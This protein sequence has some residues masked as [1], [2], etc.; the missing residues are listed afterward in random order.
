MLLAVEMER[1]DE[2]GNTRMFVDI[3]PCDNCVILRGSRAFIVC[4]SSE[5]ANRYIFDEIFYFHSFLHS[6]IELN[7]IVQFAI[8]YSIIL[9]NHN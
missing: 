4:M 2:E 8:H 6:L 1:T 5:D 3:I 9:Q 7:T